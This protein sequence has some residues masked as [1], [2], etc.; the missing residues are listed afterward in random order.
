MDLSAEILIYIQKV[1]SYFSNN[2]EATQYFIGDSDVDSFY[3]R[4]TELSKENFEKFGYPTLSK[5]QF[6]SL[7]QIIFTVEVNKD[8]L[9]N[10]N[11]DNIFIDMRGYYKICLN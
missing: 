3:K 11:Q 8:N 1:K 4:L 7:R 9:P 2:A 5:E 6:E 10:T